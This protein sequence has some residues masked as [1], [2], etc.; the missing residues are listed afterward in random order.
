M[1]S[2]SNEAPVSVCIPV[3]NGALYI[4]AAIRSALNQTVL[5]QQIVISDS[6]SADGTVNIIREEVLRSEVK[7]TILPTKTRG[8]VANWNSTIRAAS[9]KYIKFLFQDDLLHSDCLERMVTLAES[10]ERIGFVFSPREL[11]I[12]PSAQDDAV[13]KWLLRYR[14]L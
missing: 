9:G 1:A 14:N 6:G 7:V 2:P 5:P 12:E 8:V 4:K 3:Y 13:T 11:L 10:D